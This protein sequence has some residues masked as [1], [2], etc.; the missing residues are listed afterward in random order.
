[1]IRCRAATRI[2][3][4]TAI[5]LASWTVRLAESAAQFLC[6]SAVMIRFFCDCVPLMNA[7]PS[8][9][10]GS[11][12][13]SKVFGLSRCS[14]ERRPPRIAVRKPDASA[15]SFLGSAGADVQRQLRGRKARTGWRRCQAP[16]FTSRPPRSRGAVVVERSA[17]ANRV[18]AA[19]ELVSGRRLERFRT[20]EN[21]DPRLKPHFGRSGA[22]FASNR[23]L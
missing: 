17:K 20:F 3:C 4:P 16:L 14:R 19:L 13:K 2:R 5:N 12:C 1:M 22:R 8:L 21:S 11:N 7:S 10:G 15:P 6:D 9:I 18:S 23:G